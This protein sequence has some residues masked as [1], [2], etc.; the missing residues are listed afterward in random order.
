MKSDT[1]RLLQRQAEK[2]Q[3]LTLDDARAAELAPVV[4]SYNDAVAETAGLLPYDIDATAFFT[5]LQ[6]FRDDWDPS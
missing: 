6:A 4:E 2:L 3:E 5:A 1:A